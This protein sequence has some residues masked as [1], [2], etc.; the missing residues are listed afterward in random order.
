M[1]SRELIPIENYGLEHAVKVQRDAFYKS[2]NQARENFLKSINETKE[3]FLKSMNQNRLPYYGYNP[4]LGAIASKP[5]LFD[6]D[7]L[8]PFTAA[9]SLSTKSIH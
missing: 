1:K 9:S 6:L 4:G 7:S 5:F 3:S 8:E 2:I